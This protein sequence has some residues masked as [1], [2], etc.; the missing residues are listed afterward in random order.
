[1]VA[2]HVQLDVFQL[3]T[4]LDTVNNLGNLYYADQ[5]RLAENTKFDNK[6]MGRL[7]LDVLLAVCYKVGKRRRIDKFS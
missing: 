1:M 2:L 6:S 7:N 5:G 4:A 3:D